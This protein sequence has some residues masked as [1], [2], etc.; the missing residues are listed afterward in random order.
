[1]GFSEMFTPTCPNAIRAIILATSEAVS[2]GP[3]AGMGVANSRKSIC[4]VVEK[5]LWQGLEDEA[6]KGK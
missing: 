4:P 5:C 3:E 1:M 2:K 6:R